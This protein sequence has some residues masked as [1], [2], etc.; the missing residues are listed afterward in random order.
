[1]SIKLDAW[2]YL[3]KGWDG[4]KA[5]KER[6]SGAGGVFFENIERDDW[7]SVSKLIE[8]GCSSNTSVNRK[9]ALMHAAEHGSMKSLRLL[10]STGASIGV[11]D[12]TGRDAAFWAIEMTN[13]EALR[14]ILAQG[15]D[16]RRLFADNA[17]PLILAAKKSYVEGVKI[18]V[19][20]DPACVNLRDRSGRTALW[21]VLSKEDPTYDDNEIARILMDA[22]ADPDTLDSFGRSARGSVK[23]NASQSELDRHD[24]DV[25][26]EPSIE[27]DQPAPAAPAPRRTPSI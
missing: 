11:Q 12:E 14:C 4:A 7:L 27:N 17:T 5:E 2:E 6:L 25:E 22:G 9:T 3:L 13:S 19:E 10:I 20:Y 23:S 21:H 16:L 24:L 8:R 18:V 15:P 1:M 26:I